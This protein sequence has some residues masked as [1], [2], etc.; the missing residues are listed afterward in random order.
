MKNINKLAST[1]TYPSKGKGQ[2]A[3]S[4]GFFL[5]SRFDRY[6]NVLR[7]INITDKF[8]DIKNV[9]YIGKSLMISVE[10][11]SKTTCVR[12]AKREDLAQ[13]KDA[14]ESYLDNL[15]SKDREFHEANIAALLEEE[16]GEPVIEE[17][18]VKVKKEI[19]S[20]K[21]TETKVE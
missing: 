6:G 17:E 20:K 18:V 8:G 14:Y 13:Y 3:T 1:Y 5:E 2:L 19:K 15:S 16:A 7:K 10:T 21:E 11:S 12:R 9:S 4:V